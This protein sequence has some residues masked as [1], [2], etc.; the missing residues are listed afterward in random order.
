[1]VQ[2]S[3][4]AFLNPV[5]TVDGDTA[6]GH[7]LMW[8]ASLIADSP[9]TV[10]MSADMTCTRTDQGWRVHTVHVDHGTESSLGPPMGSRQ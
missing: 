5:I 10:Y 6:T 7:W 3:M 4:H 9:R 1:M 8:I 2:F